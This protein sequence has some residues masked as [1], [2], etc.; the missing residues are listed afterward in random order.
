MGK[1]PWT[2]IRSQNRR[3]SREYCVGM[4][5]DSLGKS[6]I[7]KRFVE[8]LTF[9]DAIPVLF[10]NIVQL[11]VAKKLTIFVVVAVRRSSTARFAIT[12]VFFDVGFKLDPKL[13][14]ESLVSLGFI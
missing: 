9:R 13:F 5:F 14:R 4:I 10:A 7:D 2:G 11:A 1:W 12:L 3:P 6:A 8:V